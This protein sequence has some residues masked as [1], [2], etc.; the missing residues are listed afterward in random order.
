MKNKVYFLKDTATAQIPEIPPRTILTWHPM[1][2]PPQFAGIEYVEWEKFSA[3][4]SS[5]E[6][7][8]IILVGINRLITPSNRCDYVH[9]YLTT[10]TPNIPK[11]SIDSAPFA[12]EPWRLFFHYLY[13]N[14]NHFGINYS[15]PVEREWQNWFYR[16]TNDCRLSADNVGMFIKKTWSNLDKLFTQFNFFQPNEIQEEWYAEAKKHVFAKNNTPK[17]IIAALLKLANDHFQTN[18]S[19][20]SWKTNQKTVVPNLGVYRFMIEENQRRMKIYNAFSHEE[21]QRK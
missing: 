7:E 2:Q 15:Y 21:L 8:L 3:L 14:E 12:G 4:Y 18:I 13:T 20:D 17:L 5:F 6:P 1:Y 9:E 11:I 16:E 10:M 19:Y